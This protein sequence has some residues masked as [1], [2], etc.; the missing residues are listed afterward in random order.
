MS[1]KCIIPEVEIGIGEN[2]FIRITDVSFIPTRP[3][4]ISGRPE[5]CYEAEPAVCDWGKE[6]AQLVIR[7]YE[8]VPTDMFVRDILRREK[9][10]RLVSEKEFPVDDS[11]VYEYY[12]D[13]ITAIEE[14]E[15]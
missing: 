9:V 2:I 13:I 15:E 6:N 12:Q 10:K 8:Y 4:Y 1:K 3:A 11:F 7:K 5:D 14:M